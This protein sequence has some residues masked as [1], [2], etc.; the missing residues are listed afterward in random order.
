MTDWNDLWRIAPAGL[1]LDENGDGLADG[2][3][4]C[5]VP[6]TPDL[7]TP[8]VWAACANFA[9][10]AWRRPPCACPWRK[11]CPAST[12]ATSPFSSAA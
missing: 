5:I 1:L 10:L 8:A 2:A 11:P 6:L 7:F 12:I 9:A 4:A 3:A